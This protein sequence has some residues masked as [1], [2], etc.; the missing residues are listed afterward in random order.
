MGRALLNPFL[1]IA[2]GLLL[3]LRESDYKIEAR[4]LYCKQLKFYEI[5]LH[6]LK[7]AIS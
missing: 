1:K 3:F 6:T 4:T 7:E 5:T 2:K